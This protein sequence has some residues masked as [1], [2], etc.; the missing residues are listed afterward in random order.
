MCGGL[1]FQ[2]RSGEPVRVLFPNPKAAMLTNPAMNTWLPWGRRREEPGAWPEGGWAR[3][4]SVNKGYWKRWG[5][6][7]VLVWPT[8]WMEKDRQR[9]SQWFDLPPGHALVCL[10]LAKAPGTPLYVVTSEAD[11]DYLTDIHDRIPKLMPVSAAIKAHRAANA[12]GEFDDSPLAEPF[13]GDPTF[14]IELSNAQ[15]YMD[16]KPTLPWTEEDV[17]QWFRAEFVPRFPE[18]IH[19]W[20][21]D[22]AASL[23]FTHMLVGPGRHWGLAEPGPRREPGAIPTKTIPPPTRQKSEATALPMDVDERP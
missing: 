4:E 22:A 10:R 7:R 20:S 6:E 19:P 17:R 1:E 9:R 16:A 13:E 21:E 15:P 5:S 14:G 12:T 11:G 3:Y 8:R 2:K 18:L 23:A